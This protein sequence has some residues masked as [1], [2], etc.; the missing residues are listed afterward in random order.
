MSPVSSKKVARTIE[1]LPSCT[2]PITFWKV[3]EEDAGTGVEVQR[4]ARVT[5]TRPI[6][7]VDC[8]VARPLMN[9]YMVSVGYFWLAWC[10]LP[11]MGELENGDPLLEKP[12]IAMVYMA[13][14]IV[15][16]R[17]CKQHRRPGLAARS[18]WERDRSCEVR[19]PEL[20]QRSGQPCRLI[21]YSKY[22]K[23]SLAFG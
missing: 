5:M 14:S 19:H 23:L 18:C 8:I 1:S 6:K 15:L 20:K 3:P 10:C 12:E 13:M 7:G 11:E 16:R 17:A 22:S 4:R 2:V 21:D 9:E